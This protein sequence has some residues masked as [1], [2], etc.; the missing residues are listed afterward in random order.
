MSAL[1]LFLYVSISLS[2]CS[3][4]QLIAFTYF[5]CALLYIILYITLS[6]SLFLSFFLSFFLSLSF[7]RSFLYLFKYLSLL[8]NLLSCCHAS[9]VSLW[10]KFMS[11]FSSFQKVFV[12]LI[13]NISSSCFFSH[14]GFV[15]NYFISV[16]VFKLISTFYPFLLVR[17]CNFSVAIISFCYLRFQASC[18]FILTIMI[19]FRF[20][21]VLIK[22]TIPG[23][24]FVFS[25]SFTEQNCRVQRILK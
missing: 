5:E 17:P 6:L 9:F 1:F 8:T 14:P 20:L 11:G 22:W 3:I 19:P 18:V 13:Q 10:V 12:F 16:Y 23:L 25:H 7:S 4:S 2:T 21:I 24:F 15:F